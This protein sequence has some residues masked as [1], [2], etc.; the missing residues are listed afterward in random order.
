LNGISPLTD[1]LAL[2]GVGKVPAGTPTPPEAPASSP[3]PAAQKVS[4]APIDQKVSAAP[5]VPPR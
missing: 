1:Y 3:S 4:A 5:T 2:S